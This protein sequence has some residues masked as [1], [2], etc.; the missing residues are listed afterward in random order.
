VS[1]GVAAIESGEEAATV[2]ADTGAA[3]V[4]TGLTDVVV[5]PGLPVSVALP[6]TPV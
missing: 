6:L 1:A 2:G 4:L 5:Q 3:A